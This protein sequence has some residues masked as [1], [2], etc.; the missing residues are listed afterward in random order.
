[1]ILEEFHHVET[2]RKYTV[3]VLLFYLIHAAANDWKSLRH[4]SDVSASIGLI[5]VDHSSLLIHIEA[6]N[7][8]IMKRI[9]G[10]VVSKLNRG[11]RRYVRVLLGELYYFRGFWLNITSIIVLLRLNSYILFPPLY[12]SKCAKILIL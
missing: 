2:A 6:L 7:Y 12:K 11:A 5:S 10:V 8:S 4:A 1:M 9:F 3:F